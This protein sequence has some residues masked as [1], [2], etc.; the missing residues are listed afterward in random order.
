M[1]LRPS[2]KYRFLSLLI[3]IVLLPFSAE[4]VK[5]ANAAAQE[6]IMLESVQV[7]I[8]PEYDQPNAL[9]FYHIMLSPQVTLP[10]TLEIRIPAVVGKPHAVAMQDVAGL[11][12][13]NYDINAAG[14]WIGIQF[15][16][17]VP[18]IRIEYYDPTLDMNGSKRDFVF[19]WPGDYTVDNLSISVQQPK[20]ASNMNFRPAI[21]EGS[22]GS[23]GLTYYNLAAGKI[24]Q[25]TPLE[26]AIAYDKPDDTLT[27]PG[28]FQPVQSSQPIDETAAGRVTFDQVLPWAVGGLG[29]LLIVSSYIWYTQAGRVAAPAASRARH[30]RRATAQQ[31]A[32]AA[33]GGAK[34]EDGVFC[35]QCG[36]RATAGD[37]FCRAC[38][39]KLRL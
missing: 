3:A 28:Q 26:L 38:G 22:L 23:D 25:G 39:T 1:I 24:N 4:L 33:S 13:L 35:H 30:S 14:E 29:I 16:T 20:T 12:N 9:V 8:W 17:P 11:Y 32:G 10:A 34:D 37:V 36:K 31:S 5:P 7:E 2:H 21:G 15:T 19:R 6:P 27:S 18:D